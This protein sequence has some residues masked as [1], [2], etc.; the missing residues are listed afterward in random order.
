MLRNCHQ[1]SPK[2][3]YAISPEGSISR[4][5]PTNTKMAKLSQLALNCALLI[6]FLVSTSSSAP[7]G[8]VPQHKFDEREKI[9]LFAS[10]PLTFEKLIWI[11]I[12]CQT[13]IVATA[14]KV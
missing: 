1:D 9:T 12:A 2:S 7:N 6:M 8:L 13:L 11:E 5:T 3:A 14:H 10:E 4:P